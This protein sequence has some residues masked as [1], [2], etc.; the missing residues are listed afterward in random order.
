MS[1][2][3]WKIWMKSKPWILRWFI[4]LV[5][6]RPI[7][8]NL[9]F[10]KRISPF[11]SP[12][13]IVG[14]LTP[15]LAIYALAKFSKPEKSILDKFVK[16]WSFFLLIG[17]FFV[18][19]YDPLSK[20]SFEFL[21]KLTLPIYLYFFARLFIKN[22]RDLDGILTTFL[23]SGGFVAVILIYEVVFG[24]IRVVESRGMERIQGSFGDVVSYGIYLSFCFLI[25]CYFYLSKKSEFTKQQKIR[26]LVIVG[27]LS[28]LTLVNIHHVASYSN[29]IGVLLLFMIFNFQANKGGA[30]VLSV[31]FFMLFYMFGQPL[32]EEKITPL[33]QTD[34]SVYEGDKGSDKL[35]HGRVGRWTKMYEKFTNQSIF[36]QFFGYPLSLNRSYQ[37]VGVG[38]HN[39]YI[40]ILFLSG[41][42]GIFYYLLLLVVYFK[43]AMRLA[44]ETKF[45][46]LGAL[47]ILM[48]FSISIVPTYYPP[49]MYIVMS[50]FAFVALP[51]KQQV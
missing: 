32:I 29:F 5:L 4:L 10:L 23:F 9:F 47:G 27:G 24:A 37:Y 11:L 8:D 20:D 45:L 28:L 13:Y 6:L 49:F 1:F 21:L 41:Y 12:L 3:N 40:R 26:L 25:A 51:K 36:A 30:I 18:I 42:F 16:I 19:T 22:K 50:V 44:S 31:L 14:V 35:L 33:L 15:F 7:I 38:S 39:D 34:I 43:K 17:V 2:K 48:L 46:A